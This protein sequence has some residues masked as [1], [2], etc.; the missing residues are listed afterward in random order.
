MNFSLFLRVPQEAQDLLDP[1]ETKVPPVP[2]VNKERLDPRVF[3]V[4]PDHREP[5]VP[6]ELMERGDHAVPLDQQDH[7]DQQET[8]D[9]LAPQEPSVPRVPQ[10]PREILEREVPLVP[11]EL[12]V[13][14]VR[15]DE[16][17]TQV[18]QA[19]E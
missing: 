7:Q 12:R 11:Q 5:Q 8:V 10:V 17:V 14:V 6:M 18:F 2:Q 3:L 1:R 19:R 9:Q 13:H 16:M 4:T 15:L